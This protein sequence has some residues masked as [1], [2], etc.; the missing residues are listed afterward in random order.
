MV[1][2][3]DVPVGARRMHS[4]TLSI[5]VV[6]DMPMGVNWKRWL[7]MLYDGVSGW[8][9]LATFENLVR[10]RTEMSRTAQG[11]PTAEALT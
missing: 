8:Y 7:K 9:L 6:R 2:T 4:S 1:W 3:L 5:V 10:C 11:G